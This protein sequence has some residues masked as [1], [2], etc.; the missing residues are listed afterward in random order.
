MGQVSASSTILINS[1]PAIVLGGVADYRTMLPKIAS[2]H[3]SNYQVLQGGEGQG[4][5]ASWT[6]QATKSRSR[7]SRRRTALRGCAV[8]A[9]VTKR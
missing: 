5:V 9:R 1:E 7:W 3:Y 6:L 2:P 8:F 4:T